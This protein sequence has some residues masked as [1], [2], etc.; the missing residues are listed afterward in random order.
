MN[1]ARRS[2]KSKLLLALAC[3]FC[4]GQLALATADTPRARR[5]LDLGWRF[6]LGEV[7]NAFTPSFDDR[8]WRKLDLPH[9]W[10]IEGPF[11]E[12]N[13]S[14]RTGG[15]APLGIGWYRRPFLLPAADAGKR[16]LV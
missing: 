4:N 11:A 9:D 14:G 1:R 3:W 10:A 13:L 16:V 6:T 7:T 15:Y 5:N 12:T 8:S 2:M